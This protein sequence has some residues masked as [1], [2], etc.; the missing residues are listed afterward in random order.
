MKMDE[1]PPGTWKIVTVAAIGSFMA[2]LD[3][4]IVNVSLATL[5]SELHASL[6][7]I[8]WVMSGYLLALALTLPLSGWLVD[9]IGAKSVYIWCFSAFTLSSILCGLAWSAYALIAFRIVQGMAGGL[10]APM[11]QLM[12]ARAAGRQ[13]PRV[14]AVMT[15]PILLAPL[16]GPVTAGAILHIAS[17][18]WLFLMNLPVGMVAML[19]AIKFLPEDRAQA[20]PRTLD[21]RGLALL[22]PGLALFLYSMDHITAPIGAAACAA[23]TTLLAL[24]YRS[25]RRNGDAALIDLRL[26]RSRVF[27]ASVTA[28]FLM[29]GIAYAGQ[30]LIPIYLVQACG[31]SPSRS[32]L[33]LVPLGLGAM[34]LY[35]FMGRLTGRFGIRKLTNFGA[36]LSLAGTL[37]LVFLAAHG[38]QLAILVASLFLR[39]IGGSAVGIPAMSAGYAAVARQDLPMATTAMNIVQRLGGPTCTT[40]SAA[41]LAWS[42]SASGTFVTA[43]TVLCALHA[44]LFFATL[45]LPVSLK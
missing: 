41:V 6:S 5:A 37:P 23:A 38:L 9:R 43:F 32:G 40:L 42:V 24:Y 35:P 7:L 22:S 20:R 14:A 1:L 19:L 31:L 30:M 39:G 17:W 27:T 4:T 36:L 16:L 28:M 2:Q 45:R 11:A 18:R 25:A 15:M 44:L 8:Q 10:L 34:C 29:N 33:L 21:L 3:A 13:L 12:V 26:F